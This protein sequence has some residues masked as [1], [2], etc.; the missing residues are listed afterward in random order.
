[1]VRMVLSLCAALILSLLAG[2]MVVQVIAQA[3]RGDEVYILAF[4]WVPLVACL[5]L[6]VLGVTG[7]IAGTVGALDRAA[8]ILGLLAAA[9]GIGLLIWSLVAGGGA[10]LAREGPLIAAFVLPVW[11]VTL[12][13]WWLLR[14]RAVRLAGARA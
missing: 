2:G 13:Q 10:N 8:M 6:V 14:R 4:M 3:V 5:C 9:A 11:A 7:A 12:T 1:M